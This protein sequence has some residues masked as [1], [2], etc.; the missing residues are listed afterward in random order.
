ML[1]VEGKQFRDHRLGKHLS[2]LSIHMSR[3]INGSEE[4]ERR[5]TSFWAENIQFIIGIDDV[6]RSGE[7]DRMRMRGSG[8]IAG[9]RPSAGL[10]V[11]DIDGRVIRLISIRWVDA[12]ALN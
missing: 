3:L 7:T 2:L 1:L 6:E 12:S 10:L 8:R 9:S 5:L 11:V 4:Y